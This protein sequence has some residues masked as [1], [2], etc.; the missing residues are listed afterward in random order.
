MC[1]AWLLLPSQ[2]G[3]VPTSPLQLEF[4][5]SGGFLLL[6]ERFQNVCLEASRWTNIQRNL[7]V[8]SLELNWAFLSVIFWMLD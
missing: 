1:E 7:N 6:L 8:S 5:H 4:M 2:L 3:A